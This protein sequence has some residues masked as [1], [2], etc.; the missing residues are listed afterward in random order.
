MRNE[1][2]DKCFVWSILAALHPS[3]KNA[4][5]VAKYVDYQ[6]ELQL[7]GLEFPLKVCHV[8]KFETL[9]PSISISVFGY[10]DRK[11]VYPLYVSKHMGRKHIELLL[12]TVKQKHHYV[13]IKNLSRLLCKPGDSNGAKYWCRFCL[14]DFIRE[15]LLDDHV[16]DC[17]KLGMQK[18]SL[19]DESDRWLHFKN[20]Q[21]M[22]KCRYVI[23]ADFETYTCKLQGPHKGKTQRYQHMEASGYCFYVVSEDGEEKFT[24][25]VYRDNG[26]EDVIE[27][28][29]SELRDVS[30]DITNRMKAATKDKT[31]IITPEQEAFFQTTD[32]CYLCEELL[33]AD[34]VSVLCII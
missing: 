9:N 19:P 31:M 23:Y 15:D 34:R 14:H 27:K 13:W 6:N 1:R 21:K 17:S 28:F 25:R 10:N 11:T 18:V 33:G 26:S 29:L 2:D 4:E 32:K 20:I 30:D 8:S 22:L 5:R 3:E 7:T 16:Q 24:P 12:L